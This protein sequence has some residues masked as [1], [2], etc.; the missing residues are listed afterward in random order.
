MSELQRGAS[1]PAVR[2]TDILNEIILVAPLREQEKIAA[3]LGVAQQTIEQQERLLALTTDLKKTLLQQLFTRG[4][5]NESQKQTDIG[6]V[7]KSW[8]VVKFDEAVSIANGQ[9]D[10][11]IA[12]YDQMLHVGPENIESSTGRL[13][14]LRTNAEEHIRSG[15]YLFTLDDVLYSKIRPYL[16]KA[17]MPD[18]IGTC[19][20]D[21]YPLRPSDQ[22]LLRDFL[23]QLLL[24]ESFNKQAISFQDRTGIPKI[25]RRQLGLILIPVPPFDEQ[26][27]IARVLSVLDAKATCHRRKHA[28][29]RA[30]FRTLLHQLMTAKI[31]VH[32]IDIPKSKIAVAA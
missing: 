8:E 18:F 19:S 14:Q 12:P 7:P 13:L 21:M 27:E 31:R 22:R 26:I 3:V 23:F 24:S 5:R 15:N 28:T 29:L 4:L 20:A 11:K 30:L 6:P 32:D 1:Y 25:N 10:P 2:D 16:K 9:V 17:A